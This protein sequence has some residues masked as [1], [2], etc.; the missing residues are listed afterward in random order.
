MV[1]SGHNHWSVGGGLG[2]S[3]S[4][5]AV[6]G[7]SGV[8]PPAHLAMPVA[9][10]LHWR[11]GETIAAFGSSVGV[12]AHDWKFITLPATFGFGIGLTRCLRSNPA[13]VF[14]VLPPGPA[15]DEGGSWSHLEVACGRLRMLL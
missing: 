10:L 12:A 6:E 8:D 9:A 1:T 4:R 7:H 11:G 3:I 5:R 15:L 14:T 2:P 13:A